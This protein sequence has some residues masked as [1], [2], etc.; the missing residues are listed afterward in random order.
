MGSLNAEPEYQIL[1]PCLI[2]FVY[3]SKDYK[4]DP[5]LHLEQCSALWPFFPL[6]KAPLFLCQA[7]RFTVNSVLFKMMWAGYYH[8]FSNLSSI[9]QTIEILFQYFTDYRIE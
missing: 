9:L 1:L 7:D 6:V 2:L 4:V 8:G 3:V 5:K